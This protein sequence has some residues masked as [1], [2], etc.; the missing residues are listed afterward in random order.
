M[1]LFSKPNRK[2]RFAAKILNG[3]HA[4]TEFATQRLPPQPVDI[5]PDGTAVRTL[6][7]LKGGSFSHFELASG[8]TS[9]AV[10][11]RTVEEIWYF[12]GGRGEMWRQQNDREEIVPVDANLCVTIP[13]GT[14]FQFRCTGYK[15]LTMLVVTIPPWPGSDE[16]YEVDGRWQPTIGG[17]R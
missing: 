11:H 3:R 12:L 16:A 6:L 4:M 14:R 8:K 2:H 9:I 17:K 13:F 7:R 1:P 5:A 15:P 10:A